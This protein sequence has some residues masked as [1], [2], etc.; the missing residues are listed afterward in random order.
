M[1]VVLRVLQMAKKWRWHVVLAVIGLVGAS[2]LGLVTPALVRELTRSIQDGSLTVDSVLFYCGILVGAYV[3]RAICRFLAMSQSHVAAWEYVGALT[4]RCYDKLQTL[5]MKFYSDKQTGQLMSRIVNDTRLLEQLI[6]H[7]LP[8]LITNVLVIIGVSV[9]IFLINPTLALVTLVPV[10]FVLLLS[11]VFSKKVMPLF[12]I[13]AKVLGDLNGVLQ[14]NLSGIKEIQAFGREDYEHKKMTR[15]CRHYSDVN[16]HANYVN[17]VYHPSVEL[18]TSLGTIAVM[19]IGGM[20]SLCGSM[21][22]A[23][24]IGFF[25]YL[26]LFYT[27]LAALARLVEDVQSAIAGGQRVMELLDTEPDI[28]DAPDA[29]P[30]VNAKGRL[31]FDH[32]SFSYN[33]GIKVIDDISFAAE[34]GEMVALVGATGVGKT[35]IM[36]LAGRFYDADQG[37]IR[38]DGRNIKDITIES[39]RKNLS[40]VIQDVF[41]FNGSIYDNIAYGLDNATEEQVIE[42]AKIACADE[43]IREMPDGYLT[44][45]G[46]R[47]VRLSGGQKQRLAIARAVLRRSPVLMLDEATSAV[48]METEAKIQA[49]LENLAGKQTLIVIAH[50]LSTIRRADKILVLESGRIAESGTHDELMHLG[51]IYTKLCSV[52]QNNLKT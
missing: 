37:E 12:K 50:R 32:V 43:F 45:I 11:R 40:M 7:A 48:D 44:L 15:W 49:A 19:G 13:N 8:D 34:P 6:A 39:L 1:N 46:E 25:M 23:D 26:S 10:P 42:A 21:P 2:L 41:L 18:I 28:F 17:A 51:G 52:Q 20:L 16:I 5:S 31:E 47:G 30:L 33:D 4:L 35:T 27:P 36:S 22:L 38:L 14:D 29:T 9:M 24:I 3:L